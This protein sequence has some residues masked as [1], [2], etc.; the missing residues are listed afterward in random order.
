MRLCGCVDVWL[1]FIFA[2][3]PAAVCKED[4]LLAASLCNACI[5]QRLIWRQNEMQKLLRSAQLARL[6][7][8]SDLIKHENEFLILSCARSFHSFHSFRSFHS[9][10]SF[11]PDGESRI[12]RVKKLLSSPLTRRKSA[13]NPPSLGSGSSSKVFGNSLS[14]LAHQERLESSASTCSSGAQSSS[15]RPQKQ[16]HIPYV[17]T[18]LCDYIETNSGLDQEGKRLLSCA[19]SIRE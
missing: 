12:D 3:H 4:T 9:F 19:I 15:V 18:R 16:P 8:A 6:P 14:V 17:M 5:M 13:C 7:V 11:Q 1:C 2:S 10:H